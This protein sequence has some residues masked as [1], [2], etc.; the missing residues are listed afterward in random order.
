MNNDENEKR[1]EKI[2]WFIAE[3]VKKKLTSRRK[4]IIYALFVVMN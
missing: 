1:D 3:L 4:I 2:T